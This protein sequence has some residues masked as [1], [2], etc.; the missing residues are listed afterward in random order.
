MHTQ[1]P[2][3]RAMKRAAADT[4]LRGSPKNARPAS[5]TATSEQSLERLVVSWRNNLFLTGSRNWLDVHR[6]AHMRDPAALFAELRE[7]DRGGAPLPVVDSYHSHMRQVW[8]ILHSTRYPTARPVCDRCLYVLKHFRH[9]KWAPKFH[10]L[11]PVDDRRA[12]AARALMMNGAR[13]GHAAHAIDIGPVL[14]GGQS[15]FVPR[16]L[17]L[18][19]FSYLI[20]E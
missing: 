6:A 8:C 11:F 19:I 9:L 20:V 4:E 15:T 18:H 16:D 10:H 13:R 1:G 7:Y 3:P 2:V 14:W 5:H 17:W 12:A